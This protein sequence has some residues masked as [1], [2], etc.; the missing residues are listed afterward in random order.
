MREALTPTN[1]IQLDIIERVLPVY[2][3]T[4]PD[5]TQKFRAGAQSE[6]DAI[7]KEA[8]QVA[9][10]AERQKNA[11]EGNLSFYS[12]IAGV[13]LLGLLLLTKRSLADSGFGYAVSSVV[14]EV[15][16][17]QKRSST[18][19]SVSSNPSSYNQRGSTNVHVN[20]TEKQKIFLKLSNG[21][22]WRLDFTNFNVPCREMHKLSVLYAN[23]TGF[24]PLVA[25]YHNHNTDES[26][27]FERAVNIQ[28][29]PRI[30]RMLSLMWWWLFAFGAALYFM[31]QGN[32][33]DGFDTVDGVLIAASASIEYLIFRAIYSSRSFGQARKRW[34]EIQKALRGEVAQ[35]EANITL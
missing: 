15:M 24:Q 4:Y 8:E 13:G 3:E 7:A 1:A 16:R 26:I 30:S 32:F 27:W 12:I 5:E 20:T 23:R 6:A 2:A 31:V 33:N 17:E 35:N 10:R 18:S 34:P 29:R 22:E 25:G 11:E 21:K 19:I 14:G 9:K 28:M